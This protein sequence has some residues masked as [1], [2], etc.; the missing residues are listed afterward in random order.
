[1]YFFFPICVCEDKSRVFV[2]FP[3]SLGQGFGFSLN[4][5]PHGIYYTVLLNLTSVRCRSVCRSHGVPQLQV[6]HI[7]DIGIQPLV[8]Q[9]SALLSTHP[10]GDTDG[11]VPSLLCPNTFAPTAS[12]TIS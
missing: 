9:I 5:L 1:M 4:A 12:D 6:R 2:F 8:K 11:S 7:D 3:E 10:I